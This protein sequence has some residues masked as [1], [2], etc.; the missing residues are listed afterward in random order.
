ML[1]NGQQMACSLQVKFKQALS[2]CEGNH[3][4]EARPGCN[5]ASD[6]KAG[7]LASVW[8]SCGLPEIGASTSELQPLKAIFGFHIEEKPLQI[9]WDMRQAESCSSSARSYDIRLSVVC[10]WAQVFSSDARPETPAIPGPFFPQNTHMVWTLKTAWF[11]VDEASS[12]MQEFEAEMAA[13]RETEAGERMRAARLRTEADAA[14]LELSQLQEVAADLQG[15]EQRYWHDLNDF[16]R[17]LQVHVEDRDALLSQV[18]L[19]RATLLQMTCFHT[20]QGLPAMAAFWARS[21]FRLHPA[22]GGL[23]GGR[24]KG[25]FSLAR[26]ACSG[27]PSPE[28]FWAEFERRWVSA[29]ISCQKDREAFL[30]LIR[31]F[32]HCLQWQLSG[33][34]QS[35]GCH[36]HVEYC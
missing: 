20:C 28:C 25:L 29:Q 23:S 2:Q 10:R 11:E 34:E 31:L 14:E 1:H 6:E 27:S 21:E 26:S 19:F 17:Q 32:R 18:G 13:T 5:D 22:R 35:P 36:L 12:T 30:A 7:Q 16:Q 33:P 24:V 8:N 9:S 15:L 4:L 3:W